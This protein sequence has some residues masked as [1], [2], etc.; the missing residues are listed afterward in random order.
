MEKKFSATAILIAVAAVLFF[1]GLDLD[2]QKTVFPIHVKV[3][4]GVAGFNVTDKLEFGSIPPGSSG[5]KTI[6]VNNTFPHPR[7]IY[8]AAEGQ[9]AKWVSVSNN[10]FPLGYGEE[11]DIDVFLAVPP[12][13]ESGDYYGTLVLYYR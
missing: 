1:A 5:K 11:A 7:N 4:K 3:E 2:K 6:L 13:T 10:S 12:D 9:I 8:F